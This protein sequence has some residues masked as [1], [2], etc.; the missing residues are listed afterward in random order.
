MKKIEIK[1]VGP[2]ANLTIGLPEGGGV[3]VLSGANG[4]GKSTALAAV[5][6]LLTGRLDS[7]VRD[8]QPFGS[9]SGLGVTIS[10]A[11]KTRRVGECE[12]ASLAGPDPSILVDPG[13]KGAAEANS[14]RL[15]ALCH[16]AGA[17]PDANRFLSICEGASQVIHPSS[18]EKGDVP[19]MAA[20]VKRDFER[21]ARRHESIAEGLASEIKG[22]R[23]GL[24]EGY[25]TIKAGNLSGL[26]EQLA[27]ATGD[28]RE[29][30][31]RLSSINSLAESAKWAPIDGD[32]RM[33][34][35]VIPAAS[36]AVSVDR[37]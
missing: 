3:V 33:L 6:G 36:A 2:I 32:V 5:N 18:L 10:I 23:A 35:D 30:E 17:K 21:E 22:I 8:G 7:T 12:V 15:S 16:I 34:R 26:R 24:P 19:V 14:A 28:I 37:Q 29:L 1:N 31:G 25:E 13:L 9:V 27:L 20:S 4:R 11:K